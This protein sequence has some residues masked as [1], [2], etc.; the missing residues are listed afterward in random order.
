MPKP[1]ITAELV[2]AAK[3][4]NSEALAAVARSFE[5]YIAK[6]STRPFYDEY[7]KRYDLVD[8]EIRKHIESRLLLQIVYGFNP[9]RVLNGETITED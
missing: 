3:S 6:A 2:L 5:P 7:G 9:D 4:G 1:R 8:E